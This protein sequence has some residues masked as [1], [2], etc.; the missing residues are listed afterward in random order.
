MKTKRIVYLSVLLA[1]AVVVNY[2]ES[3]IPSFGLPGV[4]LGLTNIVILLILYNFS[5]GEA[6]LITILRVF[7]VGLLRGSLFQVTF[8]MSL[9]G[10]FSSAIVM[11]ALK[12]AKIFTEIGVSIGGAFIHVVCQILVLSFFMKTITI[13]YYLPLL[14]LTSLL[15]GVFVGLV[16]MK[17]RTTYFRLKEEEKE[18]NGQ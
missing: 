8:F 17:V 15:T 9:G 2:A 1:I 11:F 18:E 12:K 4:R 7:L 14:I 3:L 16:V 10:A 6:L 5:F 13:V